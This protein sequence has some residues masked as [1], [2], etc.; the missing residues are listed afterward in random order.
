MLLVFSLFLLSTTLVFA[1]F[2]VPSYASTSFGEDCLPCHQSG[3]IVST[4]ATGIIQVE[5]NGSFW[6]EV[7]AS[8]GVPREMTVIWSNVS[9]NPYFSFT[10]REVE[11]NRSPDS[12][13]EDG[14]ITAFFEI[15]APSIEG[16]FTLKTYAA[17]AEGRGGFVDVDVMVGVGGEIP[18]IPKTPL[19]IILELS[20]KVVPLAFSGITMLG[21]AI[22]VFAWRK[23]PEGTD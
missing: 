7:S 11:D 3:I 17:S 9:Y 21:I 22:R 19:E 15:S 12:Q 13:Q 1:N 20:S 8:G 23:V 2:I 4:N 5:T 16:N 6:L 18:E 10:P 14:N